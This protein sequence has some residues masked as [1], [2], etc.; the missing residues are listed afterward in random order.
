MNL[1]MEGNRVFIC[2]EKMKFK[3][4]N[5]SMDPGSFLLDLSIKG[6]SPHHHQAKR[7][8]R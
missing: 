4:I 3:E 7:S 6:V 5:N 2:V 8:K 1:R